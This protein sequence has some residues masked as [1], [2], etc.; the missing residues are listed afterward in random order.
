MKE[1]TQCREESQVLRH[2]LLITLLCEDALI[3]HTPTQPCSPA[4]FPQQHPVP[5]SWQQQPRAPDKGSIPHT[6][7]TATQS[8]RMAW[9][10][11][12][13]KAHPAPTAFHRQ[14]CPPAAQGAQGPIQPGPECLQRWVTTASLGSSARASPP[15]G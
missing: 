14:G 3:L 7:A 9:V 8:H 5:M 10:G 4:G 12:A 1:T 15:S 13:L 11:R 6:V 2:N